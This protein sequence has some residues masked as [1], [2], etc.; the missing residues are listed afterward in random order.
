[1][2]FEV[3]YCT[4]YGQVQDIACI[5]AISLRIIPFLN[6]YCNAI[7][8]LYALDSDRLQYAGLYSM[9]I[10]LHGHYSM[11]RLTD[12]NSKY[13]KFYFIYSVIL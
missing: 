12:I 2:D 1:M 4:V 5:I 6:P 3:E 7:R 9:Y 13:V 8:F 11:C 10:I